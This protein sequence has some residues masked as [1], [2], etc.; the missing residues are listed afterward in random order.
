MDRRRQVMLADDDAG[1]GESIG[2]TRRAHGGHEIH[3]AAH[4]NRRVAGVPARKLDQLGSA[5]HIGA[6]DAPDSGSPDWR[7]LYNGPR[8]H[9]SLDQRAPA[10]ETIAW[11]GL[12]LASFGPPPFT[13]EEALAL[14]HKVDQ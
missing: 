5:S 13:P 11:P 4:Q 14:S 3:V 10:A 2:F 8:P 12:S 9:N 7:R 6:P 1:D